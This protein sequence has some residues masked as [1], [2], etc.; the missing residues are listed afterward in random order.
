MNR[1]TPLTVLAP[2]ALAFATACAPAPAS[3][4]LTAE[5]TAPA[6]DRAALPVSP[7]DVARAN[8]ADEAAAAE[9]IT[10]LF[11]ATDDRDWDAVRDVFADSVV[12]DYSALDG[13]DGKKTPGEI[14]AAWQAVMPG[15]ERT[16]HNPHNM[17]VWAV[18]QTT[19]AEPKSRATATFDALATH[20]LPTDAGQPR[21]W[22]VF[23]GYDAELVEEGGRWKVNRLRLNLYDQQGD[24][25]LPV[26]AAKL[27]ADGRAPSAPEAGTNA[28]VEAVERMFAALDRGDVDGWLAGFAEGGKQVMPLAPEGF[29]AEQI[30]TAQLRE[31]YAPV[32]TFASQRYDRE[33]Y[34]TSNPDVVLAKYTGEITVAPGK[35]YDNSYVSVFE[36]GGDGKVARFT[37]YF[38]PDILANGFPGQQPAHFS[39]HPAGAS[40]ETGVTLEEVRFD[41][42]GDELVGHLFL[43]PN[44]DS[45]EI[46][47]AV[48]VTGSWTSVKEQMPDE[49]ASLLARDGFVTLTFDFR[50]FGESQGTPRQ[51]E[52]YARKIRDIRNAVTF[53]AAH[54]N[55]S[56]EIAGLGV[57]ASA[58]YM[59]HATAQDDRIRKLAL[60]AP[61][62]HNP[63][64]TYQLYGSRP[65]G[66]RDGLL[67]LGRDAAEAFASTGEVRYDQATSELNPMAAMYVPGGVFPYYLRP[68]QGAGDVYENRWA[69]M[70]WEPWLTFDSHAAADDIDV[71]VHIVH[72]EAGAV[73]DG[74]K[75]FIE[76]LDDE[77]EVEWLN[78]FNQVELYYVPEAAD[79]AMAS[80]SAWLREGMM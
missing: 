73:P 78:N 68:D 79:Q 36:L 4:D 3:P 48:V 29:P 49:Y 5:T 56:D 44:F 33:L 8:A 50:G 41:S 46:Y 51:F 54:A 52:D 39:V 62:L 21:E 6:P 18:Q 40:P 55:T 1:P 72:S 25:N 43:P 22:T 19:E 14:V 74:A 64:M 9:A 27:V 63:E 34:P 26:E 75:A 16:I 61:W 45:S 15:F 32:A 10:A 69:V 7:A 24:R 47:P 2:L 77:P 37:E 20:F 35:E 12:V 71:P 70:S 76:R 57:C 42:E 80:T 13:I 38:N 66:G 60:V 28:S 23:A 31:Q 11:A 67:A 59:A 65:N 17:T 58:G 53:L 30:G